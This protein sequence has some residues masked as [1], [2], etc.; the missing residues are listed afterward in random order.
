MKK[1]ELPQPQLQFRPE[2]ARDGLG[3][4][5]VQRQL[6]LGRERARVP[7]PEELTAPAEVGR[8]VGRIWLPLSPLEGVPID[9]G[10]GASGRCRPARRL[11]GHV[12]GD[13]DLIVRGLREHPSVREVYHR[14]QQ[15][16]LGKRAHQ[17]NGQRQTDEGSARL[18]DDRVAV[19][20]EAVHRLGHARPAKEGG[21]G[22]IHPHHREQVAARARRHL[23]ER[24]RVGRPL[25][26]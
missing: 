13:R 18:E 7:R 17:R 4:A 1:A 2:P 20:V 24:P 25:R 3:R 14:P 16:A 6:G 15:Q 9:D 12:D 23:R 21:W 11:L 22:V 10:R 19:P 8:A 26:R 5:D